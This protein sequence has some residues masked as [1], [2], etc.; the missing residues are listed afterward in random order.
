MDGRYTSR[1]ASRRRVYSKEA[2]K[3]A[4]GLQEHADDTY[5]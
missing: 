3:R 2:V 4:V 1:A 5:D